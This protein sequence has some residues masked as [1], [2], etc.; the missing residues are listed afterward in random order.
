M[1]CEK[2]IEKN[3]T[4]NVSLSVHSKHIAEGG[5]YF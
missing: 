5:K 1:A 2:N 4:R 3:D